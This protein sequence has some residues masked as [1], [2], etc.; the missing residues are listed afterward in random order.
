MS[1]WYCVPQ[2]LRQCDCILYH[3]M[4]RLEVHVVNQIP[5]AQWIVIS[6]QYILPKFPH[7]ALNRRL[8]LP[9]VFLKDCYQNVPAKVIRHLPSRWIWEY[10]TKCETV[11]FVSS[12]KWLIKSKIPY[13]RQMQNAL[14]APQKSTPVRLCLCTER[15]VELSG[16]NAYSD[17]G[18][19]T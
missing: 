17:P 2:C 3:Q 15:S 13:K 9:Q 18:E 7:S 16:L 12:S 19:N 5:N 10:Y 11:H 4:S 14:P 1:T 8:F 6:L